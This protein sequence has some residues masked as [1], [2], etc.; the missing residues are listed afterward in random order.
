MS[1]SEEAK[2]AGLPN[3]KYV[4]EQANIKRRTIHG[5]Y[6]RNRQLFDV[7]VKGVA[8]QDKEKTNDRT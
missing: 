6:H 5:W 4:Y 1:A 7:V 2:A 8:A 3:L